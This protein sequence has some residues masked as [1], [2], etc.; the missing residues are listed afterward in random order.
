M[1]FLKQSTAVTVKMGP[2]V[3]TADGFTAKTALTIQKADVRITKN[4]AAYAA[5]SADQGAANAGAVHDEAGEYGISLDA[6]DTNTLGRM[7]VRV[8]KTG[9]MP[10]WQEFMV[11]PANVYES[12]FAGTEFLEVTTLRQVVTPVSGVLH[13]KKRDGTT[14]QYT[15]TPTTDA[16]AVPIIGLS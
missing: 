3:D 13:C 14:D 8:S 5:A 11:V 1:H 9:A 15:I 2:F 16:A 4:G 12:L 7:K 10:V 6:T